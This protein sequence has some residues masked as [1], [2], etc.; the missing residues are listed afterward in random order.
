MQNA[1]AITKRPLRDDVHALVRDRIV[2]G[3]L[4]PGRRI[5][6]TRLAAEL[7]VS[8]TPVREALLR[9][10]QEGLVESDPNRGFSAAPL[11]R[12]GALQVYPVVWALECLALTSCGPLARDR[13][14]ALRRTNAELAAEP[15]PARRHDL[16]MRWHQT[17]VEP[18]GNPYLLGLLAGLRPVVRRYECAVYM[19]DPALASR[20]VGDHA[21]ILDALARGRVRSAA[22]LL[23][24]NWRVGMGLIVKRLEDGPR[25]AATA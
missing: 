1:P 19:R 24:R 15:D 25:D 9:L 22:R 17:L 13:A 14:D 18:C 21:A 8:R 6:D 23:E 4:P 12:E 16:D 10:E 20:S 7:G 3:A 2:T 5:Q 11:T